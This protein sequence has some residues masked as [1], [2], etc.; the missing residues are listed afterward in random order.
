MSCVRECDLHVDFLLFENL[1]SYFLSLVLFVRLVV[2]REIT[3]FNVRKYGL[4]FN[5]KN[6]NDT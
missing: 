5:K 1:S 2:L 3:L 6:K 4:R